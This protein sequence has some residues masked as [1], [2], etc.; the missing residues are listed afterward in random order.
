MRMLSTPQIF[1]PAAIL[2][3][4]CLFVS[5][6]NLAE[7]SPDE[8]ALS[9]GYGYL[10]I[11]VICPDRERI[12]RFEMTN[13]DTG[14]VIKTYS[15]RD[16]SA[17]PNAW[18]SLVAIPQGHYF[19]SA[20]EPRYPYRGERE[21]LLNIQP[22]RLKAPSSASGTFEIV[23]GVV[24]YVGDWTMRVGVNRRKLKIGLNYRLKTLERLVDRYPE[25]DNR[26]EI[27]LSVMGKKA[28]KW[29]SI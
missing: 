25:Y 28:T 19:L 21:V 26:Y 6:P 23:P 27:Y 5:S 3:L 24:N 29:P 17:G 14:D 8:I 22:F 16:K 7:Q 2:W 9:P 15:R 11:R 18:M 12:A 1:K 20:Y 4:C 13:L 10:L